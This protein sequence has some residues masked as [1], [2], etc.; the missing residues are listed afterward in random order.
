LR[1]S[2]WASRWA[3]MGIQVGIRIRGSRPSPSFSTRRLSRRRNCCCV[4][5][6][7]RPLS[8]QTPEI[9]PSLWPLPKGSRHTGPDLLLRMRRSARYSDLLRRSRLL[10]LTLGTLS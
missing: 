7:Q 1:R 2:R 5:T 8:L 10:R 6:S 9:Q 3:S 4:M